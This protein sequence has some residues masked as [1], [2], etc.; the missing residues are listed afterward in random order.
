MFRVDRS[1]SPKQM[2]NTESR[3]TALHKYQIRTDV[4]FISVMKLVLLLR[5][6]KLTLAYGDP[7]NKRSPKC[8]A[9]NSCETQTCGFL[10]GVDSA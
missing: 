1:S 7:M 5:A 10:S 9:L 4:G 3:K 2:V 8:P 6:V